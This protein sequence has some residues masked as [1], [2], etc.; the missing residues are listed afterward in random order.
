M[1]KTTPKLLARNKLICKINGVINLIMDIDP[2][3]FFPGYNPCACLGR[4]RCV[5][6]T[7]SSFWTYCFA[8]LVSIAIC[9]SGVYYYEEFVKSLLEK[10]INSTNEEN[11]IKPEQLLAIKQ[12]LQNL[13]DKLD[14]SEMWRKQ[15]DSFQSSSCPH[16]EVNIEHIVQE[17]LDIYDSDKIDFAASYAN[18]AIVSTPETYPYPLN[19][20]T[21]VFGLVY[22]NMLSNPENLLQ[23]GNLP[24]N[25]FAFYGSQGRIRIKLGKKIAIKAI[26][27]D[28]L[29]LLPDRSSAPKDFEIYGLANPYASSEILLG[30]FTYELNGR[31][32][33]T[34]KIS[35]YD[36]SLMFE[37]VELHILN[38][39][40]KEEFTCLY[41]FRV[42][43]KY[44]E[45]H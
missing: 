24:G 29:K 42:H 25:C 37:Y 11:C 5:P 2:V 36:D 19:K 43:D 45:K 41:R 38:N 23:T 30:T 39:H 34:F 26:T 6:E 27:L 8:I 44:I 32:Y 35:R 1:S 22:I 7:R 13:K 40:G 14:A 31:S 33:Q 20:T 21:T 17:A 18:G 16:L 12:D 10:W 9:G 28:H 3:D 15:L 4:C